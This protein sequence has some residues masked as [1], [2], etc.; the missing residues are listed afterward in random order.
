[1]PTPRGRWSS[2]LPVPAPERRGHPVQRVRVHPAEHRRLRLRNKDADWA[3]ASAL[4]TINSTVRGAVTASGIANVKILDLTSALNGRRLC[5]NTV[6]LLE[7]KGLASWTS[8]G[9][10]DKTGV[11]RPDPHRVDGDEQL[12]HPGVAAPELLG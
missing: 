7:E 9:A 4:P 1:M 6:G 5:E 8:A 2:D 10:V 12:L 11:G 3:N